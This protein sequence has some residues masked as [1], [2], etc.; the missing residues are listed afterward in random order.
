MSFNRKRRLKNTKPF[1]A[2]YGIGSVVRSLNG[3]SRDKVFTVVGVE[4]DKYGKEFALLSDGVKYTEQ[5]PKKKAARH[6]ETLKDVISQPK[7]Q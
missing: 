6:L 7:N 4:Y 2:E 3:R 1:R 5:N